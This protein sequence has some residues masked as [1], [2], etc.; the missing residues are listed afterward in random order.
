MKRNLKRYLSAIVLLAAG[1]AWAQ[2]VQP[3]AKVELNRYLGKWFE[4]AR[5]PNRFQD[6]C[7]ANVTAQYDKRTDGEIE[8]INRCKEAGG[9]IDEAIGRARI[10][11]TNSNAKLKVRF[12]PEWLGW[13]PFLWADYWIVDLADDYSFAAV[14]GPTRDNL[15]ILSRTPTMS[16]AAYEALVNRLTAQGFDT[17]KLVKTRQE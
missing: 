11:D 4:I 10:D 13:L 3:V 1:M 8:V 12:A 6:D 16:A 7:V 14:G 15:W 9:K 17:S 5:F 2:Q